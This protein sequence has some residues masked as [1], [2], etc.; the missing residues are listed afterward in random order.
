MQPFVR[1][2]CILSCIAREYTGLGN[3][4]TP[5]PRCTDAYLVNENLLGDG[6]SRGAGDLRV[7]EVVEEVSGGAVHE[8]AERRQLHEP[9]QVDLI[10]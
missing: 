5:Y 4:T 1:T 10:L 7:E 9:R 3:N 8:S 2:I 6:Y